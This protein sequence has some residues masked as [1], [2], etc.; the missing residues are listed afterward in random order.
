MAKHH[1]TIKEQLFDLTVERLYAAIVDDSQWRNVLKSA[2][3]LLDSNGGQYFVWD[4]D[5]NQGLFNEVTEELPGR[6]VE[7]YVTYYGAIDPRRQKST[8][9]H[10]QAFFCQD[11]FDDRV[12]SKSEFY[13]DF[14]IPNGIRHVFAL[15]TT[16]ADAKTTTFAIYRAPGHVAFNTDTRE[17]GARLQPHLIRA[18]KLHLQTRELKLRADAATS[19][20]D[21]F[22]YPVVIVDSQ[23]RIVMANAVAE[24]LLSKR[25][26]ISARN[27]M[28]VA[29]R[30]NDDAAL[31]H[32][33]ELAT[34]SKQGASRIAVPFTLV[35]GTNQ[36][37][38]G[39][40]F[41][42]GP[43]SPLASPWRRPLALIAVSNPD[44]GQTWGPREM[45]KFFAFSPA[46]ARIAL[47]LAH[48]QT[49]ADAA[50]QSGITMNTARSQ[51]KSVLRK[52]NVSRQADL[53]RL[54][55]SLPKLNRD[56]Q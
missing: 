55:T 54:I 16:P 19:A 18:G 4:L 37:Y 20:L 36:R 17:W 9:L 32:A 47:A 27:G 26:G 48:G 49:L 2:A 15:T 51:L 7:A 43:E 11:Y 33:I 52:A 42:L 30:P 56:G 39:G 29:V 3:D 41:P 35:V 46:E 53:V 25:A 31:G 12:V 28:L 6:E 34:G 50:S 8:E 22:S 21:V 45:Q 1:R 14:L 23:R 10:N 13:Q 24:S 44:A 5:A 38:H 40:V